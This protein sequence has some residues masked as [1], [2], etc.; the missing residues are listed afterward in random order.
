MRRTLSHSRALLLLL[1]ASLLLSPALVATSADAAKPYRVSIKLS[2]T[3][4]AVGD[5]VKVSGQVRPLTTGRVKVQSRKA[6][7]WKTVK[8]VRLVAS[9]YATNVKLTQPGVT[10]LRVVSAR[11]K[12][13]PSGK[14]KVRNIRVTSN[15]SNPRIATATLPGGSV[16]TPYTAQVATA[17]GRPGTWTIGAG[18]LPP[19]LSINP[20]SG[21]ITG[22]PT[23]VGTSEVGVYFTDTDRRVAAKVFSIVISADAPVITTTTL[24]GATVGTAYTATLTTAGNATGTWSVTTGTLP[25]GLT[26]A[27]ATGVI[28][29]T[30]TAAGTS[31][32]TVQFKDAANRT[33]TKQLSIVVGT[34]TPPVIST[35][36]LPKGKVKRGLHGHPDD[37]RQR[38]GHLVD[39][40]RHPAGRADA[41]PGHRS[42]QWHA[43]R[44][45]DVEL[46]REVRRCRRWRGHQAAL[47][48]D[49]ELL[50]DLLLLEST[51]APARTQGRRSRT[52]FV[53]ALTRYSS[54]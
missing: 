4:V 50:P 16:G 42:D 39:R 20:V 53:L 12:G 1:I 41:G 3:N 40:D 26:L 45:G 24:P 9:T 38:P 52:V 35:T 2:D 43:D 17:D 5:T 8:R 19:G 15:A 14:S 49:P 30:P 47:D 18:A 11:S 37:G 7:V 44:Q 28:S 34:G 22:T 32:F 51:G 10:F 29:G 25:A 48:P 6:G 13:H 31:A 46:H 21:A 33:A 27:A 36:T 54:E 23:A